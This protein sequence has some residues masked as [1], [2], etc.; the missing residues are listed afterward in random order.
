MT[1]P[2]CG[3]SIAAG[4]YSASHKGQTLNGVGALPALERYVRDY[5]LAKGWAAKMR[6]IDALIHSFHGELGEEPSRP[7]AVNLIDANVREVARLKF[8][9]AY[10][11]GSRAYDSALVDWLEKFNR[12]IG[13]NIDPATGTLREGVPYLYEGVG[14][15]GRKP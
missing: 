1:C 3:W 12:S 4:D 15:K 10:G 14:K 11:Q 9:L 13:R 2:G 8:T 5:P 7:T 6:A